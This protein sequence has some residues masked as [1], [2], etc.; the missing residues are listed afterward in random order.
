MFASLS[1]EYEIYIFSNNRKAL[2]IVLIIFW[3]IDKENYF[4]YV[5]YKR[6]TQ[7]YIPTIFF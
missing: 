4:N 7:N 2:I 5:H 6:M 1:I 3:H